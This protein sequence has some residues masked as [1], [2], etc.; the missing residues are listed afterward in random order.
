MRSYG[1]A[2]ASAWFLEA[3]WGLPDQSA[4][5]A[6]TGPAEAGLRMPP[7]RLVNLPLSAFKVKYM[8][9]LAVAVANGELV[10]GHKQGFCMFDSYHYDPAR[11]PEQKVY[12]DCASNQGISVGWSDEY[13]PQLPGQFVQITGVPEGDYVLE[14]QVNPIHALPESDYSNNFAAVKLHYTPKHGK[15]PGTVEVIE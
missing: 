13:G 5:T 9:L 14:N 6:G 10:I 1:Q 7:C 11:G 15:I 3:A 4:V 8:E 12:M 2:I